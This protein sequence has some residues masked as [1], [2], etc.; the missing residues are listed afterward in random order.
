MA[1]WLFIELALGGLLLIFVLSP[2]P[3]C[4]LVLVDQVR[5]QMTTKVR[6]KEVR[7]GMGSCVSERTS[8]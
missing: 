3:H 4:P 7:V 5:S 2:H 1:I 8:P 6:L